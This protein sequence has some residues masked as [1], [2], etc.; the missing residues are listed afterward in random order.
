M[1]D[2]GFKLEVVCPCLGRDAHEQIAR[3]QAH[4]NAVRVVKKHRVIDL[5]A[6][7]V[8]AIDRAAA[9]PRW[10]WDDS[11]VIYACVLPRK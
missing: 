8:A 7:F 11:I 2:L 1:R 4:S 10:T 6:E 5:N 9:M 3:D